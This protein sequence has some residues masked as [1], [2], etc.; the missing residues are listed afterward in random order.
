MHER[1]QV[2]F[3]AADREGE[4]VPLLNIGGGPKLLELPLL[5]LEEFVEVKVCL[6]NTKAVRVAWCE[7]VS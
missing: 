5:V 7:V 6:R 2:C 1:T 4:L 3:D